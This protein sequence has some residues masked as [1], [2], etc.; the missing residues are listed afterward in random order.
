[1]KLEVSI[2]L[3]LKTKEVTEAVKKAAQLTMRDTVVEVWNESILG[4]PKLTGYN[5]RSLVG[6]VSGMGEVAKGQDAEPE[7]SVDDNKIEGAVYS[8]SGY[9]GYLETGTVKLETGTVK[10]AARPYMKPAL[11]RNF[12]AQRFTEGMKEHL[13]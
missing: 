5:M 7:K 6:E 11:D 12:T 3:N 1:M 4:S 13:K 8:T 2:Q 10:M 9:G